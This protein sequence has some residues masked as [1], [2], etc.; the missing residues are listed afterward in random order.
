[1]L[2][3]I[4]CNMTQTNLS[5]A[6]REVARHFEG[7]VS[8]TYFDYYDVINKI[9]FK[10]SLPQAFLLTAL[11]PWGSCVGLTKGH[12]IQPI[13]LL[14]PML[15]KADDPE[16]EKFYTLLHEAIHVYVRYVLGDKSTGKSSHES[17][18]WVS[19]VNR[20][21]KILGYNDI[22]LGISKVTR[23]KVSEGGKL[24]R[25]STGSVPY[26]CTYRFPHPLEAVT[27]K[28]LPPLSRWV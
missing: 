25:I 8:V 5:L 7:D 19:E 9:F 27:G 10:G 20:I 15:D 14:H 11:T 2:H 6:C 23:M 1:M 12:F 21:A 24:K 22:V 13:I 4:I 28:A 26:E 17:T 18:A 3:V 16:K